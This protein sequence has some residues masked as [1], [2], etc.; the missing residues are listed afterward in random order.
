MTTTE[1][2]TDGSPLR[3]ELGPLPPRMRDLV[4]F[5]GFPTPWF[6]QWING[7]PEF[8]LVDSRKWV[9][10]VK[11][12]LCWVCGQRL[13]TYL[14]FTVG[15]MCLVTGTSSEPP[16]HFVCATWSAKNCPFLNRPQ[17][18]RRENDLPQEAIDPPG[19]GIPRN[20]GATAVYTVRGYQIFHDDHGRPLI[21]MSEEWESCDW[22]REG[23]KATMAEVME[24]T[25]TGLPFLFEMAEK[26]GPEAVAELEKQVRAFE[27]LVE[28]SFER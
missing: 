2:R 7:E 11:E 19:F 10:A 14:A 16:A 23:R 21:H 17:M 6:V 4:I 3:V 24:S 28:K 18:V 27:R 20:P 26:Q 22:Y 5:R 25:R 8:R 15:P 9:R 13:G 1:M 12:K